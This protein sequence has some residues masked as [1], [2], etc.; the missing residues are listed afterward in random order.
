MA[1]TTNKAWDGDAARFVDADTF[2]RACLIDLNP[3]GATKIKGACHLP[4]QEPDGTINVHALYAA[5]AA[6]AGGRG[7][8]KLSEPDKR[9]A[10]R[11]LAALYRAAKL[12]VPA[13]ITALAS[14]A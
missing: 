13:S 10:A 4:V 6:L 1:G 8:V 3:K 14:G 7:G 11:K 9:L 12:P 2:C 5:A